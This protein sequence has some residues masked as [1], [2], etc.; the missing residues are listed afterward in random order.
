MGVGFLS[1]EEIDETDYGLEIPDPQTESHEEKLKGSEKSKKRKRIEG[2]D[3][4]GDSDE[5]GNEEIEKEEKEENQNEVKQTKKKSKKRKK[6]KKDR[7]KNNSVNTGA[8]EI[9]ESADSKC[10]SNLWAFFS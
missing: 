3:G 5:E 2:G 4:S 7:I 10:L 9:G 1:L 8:D 6:E